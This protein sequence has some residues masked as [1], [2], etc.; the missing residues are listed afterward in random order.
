[1][2]R[3]R[4]IADASAPEFVWHP[5][6]IGPETVTVHVPEAEEP[7]DSGLVDHL[8][9]PLKRKPAERRPVGFGHRY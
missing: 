9:R 1:M 8:G 4:Q 5:T 2:T 3:P 7:W 6:R